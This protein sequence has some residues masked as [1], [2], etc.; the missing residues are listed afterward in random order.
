M[1]DH[2]KRNQ[3]G[4]ELSTILIDRRWD[5][6]SCWTHIPWRPVSTVR[7]ELIQRFGEHHVKYGLEFLENTANKL[8]EKL[9]NK[10]DELFFQL[11]L[12]IVDNPLSP[13]LSS[14]LCEISFMEASGI[15]CSVT[16]L[17]I[18]WEIPAGWKRDKLNLQFCEQSSI[19]AISMIPFSN[20]VVVGTEDGQMCIVDIHRQH[21]SSRMLD[22]HSKWVSCI[23]VSKN[24]EYIVSGS[25]DNTVRLWHSKTKKPICKPLQCHGQC[26]SSVAVS[27]CCKYFAAASGDSSVHIWEYRY[28]YHISNPL[29]RF[30]APARSVAFTP[31]SKYIL[32]SSCSGSSELRNVAS[33]QLIWRQSL[34]GKGILRSISIT[35]DGGRILC[36]SHDGSMQV[37]DMKTGKKIGTTINWTF[38]ALHTA[39]STDNR[40][41][42]S[43]FA[44]NSVYVWELDTRKVILRFKVHG[45]LYVPSTLNPST[46]RSTSCFHVNF[47]KNMLLFAYDQIINTYCLGQQAS[48]K[49]Q[50][51]QH[52]KGR[53]FFVKI[54]DDHSIVAMSLP[55]DKQVYIWETC[56]NKARL[57][58]L[59]N[60]PKCKYNGFD[61]S[62]TGS[63]LLVYDGHWVH[64]W[65]IAGDT[66]DCRVSFMDTDVKLGR[67]RDRRKQIS[68]TN[69]WAILAST[70]TEYGRDKIKEVKFD[71]CENITVER[72]DGM[73]KKL[74][75]AK[76]KKSSKVQ[77]KQLHGWR[78]KSSMSLVNRRC[79]QAAQNLGA[80]R[81]QERR[82]R[83]YSCG[84]EVN[85]PQLYYT[86]RRQIVATFPSNILYYW[87]KESACI[88]T[89]LFVVLENRRM[90]FLNVELRNI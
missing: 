80:E 13:F 76:E 72:N 65:G 25:H 73:V 5:I 42:V 18:R 71:E 54:N 45:T 34:A 7:E 6:F 48:K 83:G 82:R 32:F 37:R 66:Q 87:C 85:G 50:P 90:Y 46:E 9:R 62:R 2:T 17:P 16:V 26:V 79:P 78:E 68:S 36:A 89:Q 10:P 67:Y 61:L 57:H 14:Y 12:H 30:W 38:Q 33:G 63:K 64:V 11:S 4:F 8:W 1:S 47:E 77:I 59:P 23:A 22:G 39:V 40:T 86:H 58:V 15:D 41:V 20:D 55:H 84:F 53:E 51:L 24:G 35:P 60:S 3:Q 70:K 19:T 43:L 27:D 74:A 69:E 56:S 28:G 29:H 81:R 88:T 52:R 44:D 21:D 75:L 49:P 31:Y